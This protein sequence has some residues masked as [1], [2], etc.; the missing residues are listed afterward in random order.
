MAWTKS[1][2]TQKFLVNM[3]EETHRERSHRLQ[4]LRYE[5]WWK[6]HCAHAGAERSW[7]QHWVTNE[8]HQ[9]QPHL[10]CKAE[11]EQSELHPLQFIMMLLQEDA[12]LV[13]L[14]QHGTGSGSQ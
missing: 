10:S 12:G 3:M 14:M 5:G 13:T 9:H 11:A 1:N 6:Q 7:H 2:Q 8:T 4:Q